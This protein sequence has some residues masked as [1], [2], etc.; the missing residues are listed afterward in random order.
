MSSCRLVSAFTVLSLAAAGLASRSPA[1]PGLRVSPGPA[2]WCNPLPL[3][4]YPVGRL[5][6]DIPNG[7]APGRDGLWRVEKTEQ[8]RELADPSALWFEGKWYLYPSCDMAWVSDDEGRTWRHQPLNV[9]DIGYAPTVV[10]HQGSFLLLAS[11]SDLYRASGPLGPFEKIGAVQLPKVAGMPGPTDPMLFSDSDG[12]LYFYWGCSPRDGI[13]AVELDANDPM[14]PIGAPACVIPFRPDLQPWECLGNW[15]QN[16]TTG[17]LEGAWMTKAGGRYYLTYSAAGTEYRT[18]A[19]GCY[20]A[21]GPLGPFHAQKRNPILR[22][23][24]GLVTGTGHGCIVAGPRDQLWAFYSVRAGAVHGFER[25]IGLDVAAIDSKGELYVPEAT[26]IP[27]R[28]PEAGARIDRPGAAGWLPLNDG[29][30]TFGS[31]AASNLGGRFAVDNN[32]VTWWQPAADDPQPVLTTHLGLRATVRA[33]RIIWRDVGLD[34][35]R[36]I[37]P[38]PFRY[39]VEAETGPDRWT[40]I[41]D[42]SSSQE[43][44]LIDYRECVP[45]VATRAR[46]IILGAPRGITPAVAEFTVF[47]VQ[48]P[49]GG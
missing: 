23:T 34:T 47:G 32:L 11:D 31:S 35:V 28:L 19:I 5:V 40:T 20:V 8:F 21:A 36:G 27:Q 17:W 46:L 29:E 12:R 39:R 24:A 16:K 1:E 44:L 13:W 42:R 45:A 2:T 43:D 41:L 48:T 30:P 15:N 26:S 4:D 10:R 33:V 38:G 18:Y 6:R 22:S 3:P 25:R 7:S 49:G 14:R 37:L 9:R